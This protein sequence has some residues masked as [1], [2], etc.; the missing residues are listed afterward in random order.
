M[1]LRGK[2]M[3]IRKVVFIGVICMLGLTGCATNGNSGAKDGADV[4]TEEVLSKSRSELSK[5]ESYTIE[6]EKQEETTI[7][8]QEGEDKLWSTS[9]TFHVD[10]IRNPYAVYLK[11]KSAE[12]KEQ[13]EYITDDE[14]HE[15]LIDDLFVKQD[16]E[17]LEK[18]KK[19]LQNFIDPYDYID[20]YHI[21]SHSINL[22]EEGEQY[23]LSID[24]SSEDVS[25]EMLELMKKNFTDKIKLRY[26][27]DKTTLL[28]QKM[29]AEI[30]T[31]LKS[32]NLDTESVLTLTTN[33]S[34]FNGVNEI[35]M[36]EDFSAE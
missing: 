17:S 32:E 16:K 11:S 25:K 1:K 19:I 6:M 31:S 7:N 30:F 35:I 18:E 13:E 21:D 27:L 28:P 3:F 2:D 8:S 33:I 22:T 20:T 23:L 10:Y 4:R 5:Q 26:T 29:E 36:P 14:F 9:F 12:G 34:N 24:I 15:K